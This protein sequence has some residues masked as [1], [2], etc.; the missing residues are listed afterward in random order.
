MIISKDFILNEIEGSSKDIYLYT[1]NSDVLTSVG[2]PFQKNISST[3]GYSQLNP[4]FKEE[5]V[6]PDDITLNFIY[7]ENN[8]PQIWSE[9]K[10]I[11]TKKWMITDDF[12]PFITQDNPD[13]VYY[14]KFK[15]IE[16]KMTPSKRGVLE[17]TVKPFSHFAYRKLQV[18]IDITSPTTIDI[19]NVSLYDYKPIV[20]IKNKGDINTIN[21]IGNFEITGLQTNEVV[22]IDNLIMTVLNSNNENRFSKCNRNWL[23]LSPGINTLAISGNCEIEIKCEF[24]VSL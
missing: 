5:D 4:M 11:E 17:A 9:E 24:P 12:I 19:N 2:I 23:T 3:D 21:K 14:L 20:V 7:V 22:E 6:E 16:N 8:I 1:F 10:L 13:Y 18:E 15:K